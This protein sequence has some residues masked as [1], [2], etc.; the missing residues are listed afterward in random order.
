MAA[1]ISATA[2]LPYHG[3]YT[4]LYESLSGDTVQLLEKSIWLKIIGQPDAA[5]QMFNEELKPFHTEAV[6]VLEHADLELEYGRWGKAW[7]ILD[8]ALEDLRNTGTTLDLPEHRLMVLTWA[9]LGI[10]HRGCVDPVPIELE[11]TRLW[12]EQVPVAE[13]TDIQVSFI[14]TIRAKLSNLRGRWGASADTS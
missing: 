10:R 6:V 1:S 5:R 3:V 8:T 11:R 14:L 7:R 13:Y 4:S 12:L 2:T 9:M